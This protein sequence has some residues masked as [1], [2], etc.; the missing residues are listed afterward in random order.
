MKVCLSAFLLFTLGIPCYADLYESFDNITTLAGNGWVTN[1]LSS[2]IGTTSWFQGNEAV[3]TAQSG[4]NTSYVGVNFNS[5]AGAGTI[6]NWLISP[7]L[8]LSNGDVISFYTRTVGTPVYPDRLEL[9]LSTDGISADVGSTATS[10]GSFTTLL[11][12]VNPSLTTSGYPSTWTEYT[13]TL[14]GLPAA[15]SGRFAFHYY[16]TNG[17]PTGSNSDYIGIDT[18]SFT[19]AAE[20]VPEPATAALLGIGLVVFAAGRRIRANRIR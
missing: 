13:A 8:D 2:P 12:T 6:S 16:V 17:G 15:V 3:F 7:V 11:L 10:V 1:N 18:L 4:A 14:S 9:R 19:D 5:A 20:G